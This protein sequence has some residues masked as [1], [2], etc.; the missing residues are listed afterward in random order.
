MR[1][2]II[3]KFALVRL[4]IL[5]GGLLI[6]AIW[7]WSTF[8]WMP[9]HSYKG[10]LPPLQA[11][12]IILQNALQQDIQRLS[13]EIGIR[14]ASQYKQLN[15]AK[16]FLET[17]LTEAGYTVK[18][19]SYKFENQLYSNLIVERLGTETPNEVVVIGGHYDSA[20]GVALFK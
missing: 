3:N 2:Q 17:A 14:N 18:Q 4:A 9:G 8:F 13:N 11:E 12:E 6:L 10:R 19:Q 1:V 7:A 15:A 5:F 20:L 16:T